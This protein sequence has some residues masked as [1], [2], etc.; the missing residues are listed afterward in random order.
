MG[1]NRCLQPLFLTEGPLEAKGST[2]RILTLFYG[3]PAWVIP[4]PK[5]GP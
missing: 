1:S 5:Q 4:I 2:D 3:T